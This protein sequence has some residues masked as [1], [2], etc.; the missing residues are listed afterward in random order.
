[1]SR[2]AGAVDLQNVLHAVV[3]RVSQ[4][5]ASLRDEMLSYAFEVATH[6][7]LSM[8]N[9]LAVLRTT[10]TA[11][12]AFFEYM[13]RRCVHLIPQRSPWVLVG[14]TASVVGLQRPST[15]GSTVVYMRSGD[16]VSFEIEPSWLT[17]VLLQRNGKRAALVLVLDVEAG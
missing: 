7:V 11:F 12:C 6:S 2:T 3:A 8:Y 15:F 14:S 13:A 16:S 4:L 5:V 1:M 17:H 9:E 10:P